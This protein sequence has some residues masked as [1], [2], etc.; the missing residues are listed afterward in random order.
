[1]D[2]EIEQEDFLLRITARRLL[3]FAVF[4]SMGTRI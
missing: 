4:F 3:A 2:R 1:M